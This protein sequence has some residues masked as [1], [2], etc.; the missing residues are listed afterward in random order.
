[1]PSQLCE[2]R[3]AL[4]FGVANERS[5]AWGIAQALH[6]HGARL[7]FT[8]AGEVLEKRVRPLGE[9]VGADFVVPCDVTRP[10]DLDA[11]FR[12]V[13]QSWGGLDI[14]VHSIAYADKADLEGR[15][16]ATSK[17]GFL[18]AQEISAYSLVELT[19]R[20]LPL[21]KDGGSIVT[22]TYYGAEK[23]VPNYNVMG[24]AKASL[25]ACVRYLAADLGTDNIRINAISAG[26]IKTLAA[27]GVRNFKAMLAVAEERSPMKRT[28][29]QRE[30]GNAALYLLSDLGSGV[31]GEVIHVDAGFHV[32]AG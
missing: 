25:E 22:L 2:G 4:I 31:T 28:V 18:R 1:M 8:Y 13:E 15:F 27:S 3:R 9:Q 24:V 14:L 32:Q 29:T 5:I 23:A 20:A 17:D 30:V 7:A 26:P 11:T 21:M 12:Q 10:E 6:E 19:R 16:H